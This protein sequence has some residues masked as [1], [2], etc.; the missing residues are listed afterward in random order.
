V[1]RIGVAH[2]LAV[3]GLHLTFLVM[4]GVWTLRLVGDPGRAQPIV[5]AGL[6]LLYLTLTPAK[7]P[8]VR[9][10]VVALALLAGEATGA[11]WGRVALLAIAATLTV[12]WRPLELW[13]P[14]FQLS[15]GCVAA[16]V[17]FHGPVA[18][19]L[20]GDESLRLAPR[21]FERTRRAVF[22]ALL[23]AVIAWVV[24]TPILAHHVGLVNPLGPLAVVVTAPVFSLALALGFAASLLSVIWPGLAAILAPLAEGAAGLFL[25]FVH[26]LDAIPLMSVYVPEAPIALTIFAI[27]AGAWALSMPRR[28]VALA[29]SL[30][31]LT[32][33]ASAWLWHAERREGLA[34]E[35][36]LRIDMLD[37]GDG[38]C[39]L[40]RS[41]GESILWDLGSRRLTL[42]R[43]LVPDALRD[44]G[45]WGADEAMLTHA[46]LDHFAGFPD[47]AGP[48]GLD[49]VRTT[50]D[51]FAV[52]E[53]EPDGPEALLVD[54]LHERGA[55]LEPVAAPASF[56][57]GETRVRVLWPMQ[58]RDAG[59]SDNNRSLVLELTVDTAA[60]ERVAL[61]TGDIEPEAAD[62]I[63]R[64]YPN[65]RAD[66]LELPHHG[67]ARLAG[68]GFV[69]A[70]D[71]RV[72]LQSSGR[73]RLGDERWDA[74]REGRVWLMTAEVGAAW[75]EIDRSGAIRHGAVRLGE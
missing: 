63:L 27:A 14:G 51:V 41:G 2:L 66:V 30:A 36:A 65:L 50:P 10:A 46:N 55:R 58:Q 15:Y 7:A 1:R 72:V 39:V 18:R 33:G 57:L 24:A 45:A 29:G 32:L 60:G 52:I 75:A 74:A 53:A 16:L 68:R 64:A 67:S 3:S 40:V 19:R 17:I 43:R 8:I 28:R 26:A 49:R 21:R 35:V 61:L 37:V 69:E 9:A 11:R 48:L 56:T 5:A 71:P 47:A 20:R 31:A 44:L 42:G 59:A 22:D 62:A 54:L 4:L 13:N 38:T 23:A 25:S 34:P 73:S 12:F 6:I 70:L